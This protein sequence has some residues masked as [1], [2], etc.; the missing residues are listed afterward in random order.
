M[1]V[2]E[3]V[4]ET[5]GR[6]AASYAVSP[7]HFGGPD[8]DAL[9]AAAGLPDAGSPGRLLD[10]GT[11]AGHT[12]FA[13]A[14]QIAH[15]EALDLTQEMLDQVEQ[16]ARQ[17][18]LSNVHCQLG[19]AED[20][21]YPD[22]AFDI[23]TSRLCAHHFQDA[24]AFAREAARVL[25][26]GG[27]LL[28]LDAMAPE[29]AFLDT[30]FNAFELLRDP[31]H[32]RNYSRSQWFAM[33]EEVGFGAEILGDWMLQQE[34]EAWVARV[35]TPETAVAHLRFLF[36]TAHAPARKAFVIEA[37]ADKTESVGIPSS[38]IRATLRT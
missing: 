32:V 24:P 20:L 36:E 15:V 30:F 9:V 1:G 22:A 31:S 7:T 27:T 8:L 29:D 14:P 28:L 21:P 11:G 16:G 17:R 2:K 33:L 13:L 18:G 25:R 10:I 37:S 6:A 38:L 3:A 19:D 5:F 35:G 12:A 26:P 34:F 23:V 4:Q